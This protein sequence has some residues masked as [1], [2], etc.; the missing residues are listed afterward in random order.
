MQPSIWIELLHAKILAKYSKFYC[1]CTGVKG[2]SQR[3]Y[4]MQ[5][6]DQAQLLNLIFYT[7]PLKALIILITPANLEP[8]QILP[9]LALCFH[10]DSKLQLQ[11]PVIFGMQRTSQLVHQHY[12]VVCYYISRKEK[13][14]Q[15]ISDLRSQQL[16]LAPSATHLSKSSIRSLYTS[17]RASKQRL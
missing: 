5:P 1:M 13:R 8:G 9:F 3:I 15:D 12:A 16:C 10:Q 4:I 14:L 2:E 17:S 6:C 11:G 7:P